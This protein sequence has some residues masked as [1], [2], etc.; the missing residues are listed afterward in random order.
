MLARETDVS[1]WR[2]LGAST[3]HHEEEMI[4]YETGGI[5]AAGGGIQQHRAAASPCRL[6]R[7]GAFQ[8]KRAV[9]P[10]STIIEWPVT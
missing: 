9:S 5:L 3:M 6:G 1:A 2:G 7:Q 10:P 8:R 4:E